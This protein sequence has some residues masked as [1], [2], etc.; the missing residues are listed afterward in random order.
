MLK[1][2]WCGSE[3]N[4]DYFYLWDVKINPDY[5]C[6]ILVANGQQR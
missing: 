3:G 1:W 2:I 4:Y 6:K 5:F